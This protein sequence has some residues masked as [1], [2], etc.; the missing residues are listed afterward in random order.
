MSNTAD[1][2]P[3]PKDIMYTVDLS[4][5]PSAW[6]PGPVPKAMLVY[7]VDVIIININPG[8]DFIMVRSGTN[9]SV[10]EAIVQVTKH[11][12]RGLY[13]VISMQASEYSCVV[14]MSTLQTR[15]DLLGKGFPFDDVDNFT[16]EPVV[17]K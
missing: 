9:G 15:D 6:G 1:D 12:E 13:R 16:Y 3:N 17:L 4:K 14:V 5:N 2:V 7:K 8:S 10:H 11:I